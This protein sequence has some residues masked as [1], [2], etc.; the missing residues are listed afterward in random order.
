MTNLKDRNNAIY[1]MFEFEFENIHVY[2]EMTV[3]V[4]IPSHI[5]GGSAC[6]D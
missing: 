2:L 3:T 6:H 5:F 1:I 4:V